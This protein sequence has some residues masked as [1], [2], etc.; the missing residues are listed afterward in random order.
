MH[1]HF[2]QLKTKSAVPVSAV[3]VQCH[4][5][6][7][8]PT[9]YCQTTALLC[10]SCAFVSWYSTHDC[11]KL[12]C[13]LHLFMYCSCFVS[14][15]LRGRSKTVNAA[16]DVLSCLLDLPSALAVHR[17]CNGRGIGALHSSLHGEWL[18]HMWRS[19]ARAMMQWRA[20]GSG[21]RLWPP[22]KYPV[23]L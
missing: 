6:Q 2:C 13:S 15:N 17:S 10:R 12:L 1:C 3:V 9:Q 23:L 11:Y 19:A 5:W 22:P 18:V 21:C 4:F 16:L 8:K 14:Q 20:L 7:L